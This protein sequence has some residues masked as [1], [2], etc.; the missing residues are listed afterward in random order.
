MF[1]ERRKSARG[2]LNRVAHFH[3]EITPT[4]RACMVTDISEG[5]AR[6]YSE[7]DMPPV[8]TLS[9][10]RDGE[11]ISR[12]CRVVWQLGGELGVEFIDRPSTGR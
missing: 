1:F 8:F 12:E 5:G 11:E 7:I 9:V 3:S 6:L 4:P 10:S 2:T